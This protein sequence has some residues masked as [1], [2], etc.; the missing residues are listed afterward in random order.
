MNVSELIKFLETQPQDLPVAYR[1]CSEQE[2][3]EAEH[4]HVA[5]LCEPRADGWIQ[6]KRP[7]MPYK[8]YLVFPGN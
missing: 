8:K 5:E 4:I 1:I 2:L 7:D 3:L 6:N